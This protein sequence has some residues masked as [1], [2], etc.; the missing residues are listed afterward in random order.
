[1]DV[2]IYGKYRFYTDDNRTLAVYQNLIDTNKFMV[3][4]LDNVNCEFYFHFFATKEEAKNFLM[5]EVCHTHM[6]LE[7][8]KKD[9]NYPLW[10]FEHEGKLYD[11]WM[12]YGRTGKHNLLFRNYTDDKPKTIQELETYLMDGKSVCL[13]WSDR[14]PLYYRLVPTSCVSMGPTSYDDAENERQSEI[15]RDFFE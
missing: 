8:I 3:V 12:Y 6:T 11:N 10:V 4:E 15:N 2:V 13:N 5:R 9:E 14:A 1:M 7:E